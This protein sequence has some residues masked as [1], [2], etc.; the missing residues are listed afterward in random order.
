[1]QRTTTSA[2]IPSAPTWRPRE[3]RFAACLLVLLTLPAA[4]LTVAAQAPAYAYQAALDR[5]GFSPGLIDD[6]PGRKT[7]LAIRAFQ[8][9]RGLKLSGVPDPATLA[10]LGVAQAPTTVEYTITE[11]DRREVSGPIPEDWNRRAALSRLGYE[12]LTELLAEQGHCSEALVQTLNP[13]RDLDRAGV[14]TV[15]RLPNVRTPPDAAIER[16]EL[17]LGEKLIWLIDAQGRRAGLLHCSIAR[18]PEKLPRGETTVSSVAFEPNY[19]FKPEMWPEVRNVDRVLTIPP[20]P[21]NPVGLCWIGLDRPGYG[22][23]GTPKPELIGKTGSHGC[24]RLTNWDA[25]RLGKRVRIGM[26]VR[27]VGG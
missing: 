4:T 12:T 19:T 18:L 22:I 6:K 16:L 3:R 8:T 13:G 10:A 25:V 26:G 5:A 20:G 17:D 15:V 1:M 14:G 7:E 21:R 27:F 11:R 9:Y 2:E 24:F 23:H